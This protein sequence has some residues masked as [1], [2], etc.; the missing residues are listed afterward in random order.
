DVLA[1]NH[2]AFRPIDVKTGPDGAVYIADWYNPIIQHGEVDFRD[3]RRDHVHGR[4]WRLTMKGRPLSEKPKIVGAPVPDLLEMLKS[5]RRW[6]RQFA[7]RELR[8]RGADEVMPALKTWIDALPKDSPNYWHDL[9]EGAWAREGLNKFSPSLWRILFASPEPQARAAA[10]RILTHRWR[11]MPD[12]MEVL[13]RAIVDDN[14]Q[15]RLW[16]LAVLADMRTPAAFEVAVRTLDNPMDENLDFLLESTA[17]E[18]TSVWLPVYQKGG[19]KLNDN[20][21]HLVYAMKATGRSDALKPLFGA[22]KAG[23]LSPEDATAV[24][25]MAGD[26]A[27]T[28]QA[29]EVAAMVND[30]AMSSQVQGLLDALVKA[31]AGRNVIP[32][33][34]EGLVTAWLSSPRPEIVH[35]AAILAGLWKI[36]NSRATLT[37]LVLKPETLPP[38]REGAVQGL[39]KLGGGKS[40]DFF[41]QLFQKNESLRALAVQ[42]LTDVG[43]PLAAKR[44]VE[45]LTSAKSAQDAAPIMAA[46]LK[47]K[48]LPNILA[49]ELAGKTIPDFVAV[50]GIRMVSSRGVPGPLLEALRT[51]GHV[52][53][54]DRPLTAEE[55]AAMV[56][57]VKSQGDPARGE[58][59]Y[60]RQ[61]LLCQTCHAIGDAGGVLGP[62][63]VSIGAS[64]PVDYLIESLLEP[65]KKIK[66]GYHMI[67]LTTT[68]GQVVAGGLVQDG[69]DE[70]VVR[71]PANQLHKVPK[72]KIA[73]RQMSPASMMPPGMTAT[74]RED[75]FVDL[76]RFLSE[77]GREGDYKIKPNRYVRTWRVMGK[78]AQETIDHVRHVGLPALNDRAHPYP[79]EVA[80][81]RVSGELPLD[82][83]VPAAKMYP[84]FPKIAQFSLKLDSPG[85]VKLG[86]NAVKAVNLVVDDHVI[87]E[88]APEVTLDLG[89]GTHTVT[90]VIGRDAGELPA[91]RI[92][93][94]DG[95]AQ[96][97]GL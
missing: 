28:T 11:E 8:E 19:I 79:W 10:L 97:S 88:V 84:W 38:V 91:L 12:A 40:R 30:P 60:R 53:Q 52:K 72:A 85:K 87:Q 27:D 63:M 59:I 81:S 69:S 16:A 3:P 73:S 2:R 83:L 29:A 44:A 68:D 90:V 80:Y 46:F 20:P 1:S 54:M 58:A 94:L 13:K 4:I 67:V 78:M 23:K 7:K 25:A 49:K 22:L 43:P 55:M 76:V 71:D 57:K 89:A 92:E 74:L 64:A 9:L 42:G 17:R 56:T 24:L 35:R 48:Q 70:V 86:L 96:L 93:V 15:V 47:N 61:Q 31:A 41:D 62:N 21:K 26:A 18:Q 51:A 50:E 66:E 14:A 33:D 82:A 37:G 77:L 36:E 39:T 95:A 5:D 32:A 75:E 45:F 65:S 34:A 6:T